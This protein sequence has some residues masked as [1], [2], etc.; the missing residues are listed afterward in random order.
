MAELT[1]EQFGKKL[2]NWVQQLR[3]DEEPMIIAVKDTVGKM[4]IRIFEKGLASDGSKIGNYDTTK[5]I[6][7]DDSQ[8]A[9]DGDHKGKHGADNKTTYFKNYQELRKKQGRESGF[10]NLRLTNRLQSEVLNK[11]L[12]KGF[13]GVGSPGDPEVVGEL[14]MVVSVSSQSL[15]KI[16][17]NEKR[18]GKN[19]FNLTKE[20]IEN[21]DKVFLF[22]FLDKFSEA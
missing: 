3:E 7:A 2:E 17:G 21:F 5:E 19:I 9:R 18:F 10:V 14:E 22:E 15:K 12:N 13:N 16:Q 8:L 20:E 6:W 4:A 11:P 1:V